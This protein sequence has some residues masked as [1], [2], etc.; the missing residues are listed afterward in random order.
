[1]RYSVSFIFHLGTR[2][3]TTEFDYAVHKKFNLDYSKDIYKV[4]VSQ[5][6]PIIYASSAATY[7]AG[8]L[9]YND[10]YPSVSFDLK[11]LNPYGVSKN[12]FD[13]FVLLEQG[14]PPFWAKR[15][16]FL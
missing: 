6:I 12:E 1:L 5:S 3:D 4:C 15:S 7:G 13:K 8:E 11:P 14:K 16:C 9:G 2:A 10:S